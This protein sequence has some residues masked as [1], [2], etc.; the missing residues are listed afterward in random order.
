MNARIALDNPQVVRSYLSHV[1]RSMSLDRDDPKYMPVT[2]DL[3]EANRQL[4]P[5]WLQTGK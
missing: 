3:S 2:R 4:I 1:A 5:A